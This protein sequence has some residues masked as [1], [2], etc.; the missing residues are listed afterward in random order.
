MPVNFN[1][2]V[3]VNGNM[4]VYGDGNVKITGNQNE[5]NINQLSDFIEN[6]LPFSPN[7]EEY[8]KA[9]ETIK[10]SNDKGLIKSA[11]N[12]VIEFGKES[13][14]AFWITGLKTIALEVAKQIATHII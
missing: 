2:N 6:S 10:N 5:I 9:A 1:G 14:K 11:L 8:K 3:T 7:R 13:G 12:K 4:E